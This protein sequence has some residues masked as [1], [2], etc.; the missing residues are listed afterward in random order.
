MAPSL[1]AGLIVVCRPS[2]GAVTNDDS[3]AR[4]RAVRPASRGHARRRPQQAEW[5]DPSPHKT[6]LVTVDD[7][8]ELE[9]LDWG[10]SG[11]ALRSVGGGGATAHHYDDFAPALTARYRVVGVTRRGHRGSSAPPTGYGFVRSPK[12]SCASWTPWA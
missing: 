2:S 4:S 10:G 1:A 7:G 9:V 6:T 12:M 3:V 8:V 11:P 5:R